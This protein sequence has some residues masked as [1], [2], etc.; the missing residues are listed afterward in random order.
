MADVKFTAPFQILL[1][2]L[3][4]AYLSST[5]PLDV[6]LSADLPAICYYGLIS[7]PNRPIRARF[8]GFL[9]T[10]CLRQ[11][12]NTSHENRGKK[13]ARSFITLLFL[14]G[15]IEPNPGPV[16]Y[17][18]GKCSKAVKSNQKGIQCDFRDHWFHTRCLNID[19]I[20]YN[21]LA[22]TSCVWRCPECGLPTYSTSLLSLASDIQ[23][24]NRYSP[25]GTEVHVSE[26]PSSLA[27]LPSSSPPHYSTP[28]RPKLKP[29]T[30]L[31]CMEINCNSILSPERTAIFKATVEHHA[32]D[33]IF[34]CES[35]LSP[36]TPT[37]AYFPQG[38]TIYRKEREFGRGGGVFL[39]VA[40][41]LTSIG[42]PE[43]CTD[44]SNESVWASIKLRGIKLLHLCSFYKPPSAPVS[45]IDYIA[46]N[47]ANLYQRTRRSCPCVVVSGDFNV[48]D[49]NWSTDPP[50]LLN[51][52]PSTADAEYLLNFLDDY[53]LPQSVTQASR[54]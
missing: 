19:S 50:T 49:I 11:V 42:H 45:R 29:N 2:G 4:F 13:L 10:R 32:P 43:F 1:L 30:K 35:K 47:L 20:T 51:T 14:C 21:A 46:D 25:L 6:S 37:G 44:D 33:V 22:N 16:K 38:F 34:G 7:A 39:A 52:S 23:S 18:C 5:M 9:K 15:D 54:L 26:S 40:D 28:K 24:P 3:F 27:V 17:P 53:S 36:D 8:V 31:K 48:G 12:L 41:N